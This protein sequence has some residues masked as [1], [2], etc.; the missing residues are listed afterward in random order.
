MSS[1]AELLVQQLENSD[2]NE[3]NLSYDIL[4]ED[5]EVDAVKQNMMAQFAGY[6]LTADDGPLT[7]KKEESASI[8]VERETE[9]ENRCE[10]EMS[11]E[12]SLQK[13]QAH[14]VARIID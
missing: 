3:G 12:F 2:D 14:A 5:K 6:S 4:D 11:Q 10:R 7:V 1:R 9:P 8:Q 13:G